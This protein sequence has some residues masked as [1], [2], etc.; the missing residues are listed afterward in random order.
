[1]V[2]RAAAD[3]GDRS[4]GLAR[5]LNELARPRLD[6][7]TLLRRFIRQDVADLHASGVCRIC[8]VEVEQ[9]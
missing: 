4:A 2:L 6:W 8:S 3:M 5:F 9:L 7:T 1:M